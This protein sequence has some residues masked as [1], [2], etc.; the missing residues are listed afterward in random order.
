MNGQRNDALV[1]GANVGS[2]IEEFVKAGDDAVY[3]ELFV[4]NGVHGVTAFV[5]FVL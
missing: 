4:Y 1:D 5:V 2:E 3:P